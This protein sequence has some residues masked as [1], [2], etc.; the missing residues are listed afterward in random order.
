M[1]SLPDIKD[2]IQKECHRFLRR[3][4]GVWILMDESFDKR[5]S[6][7]LRKFENGRKHEKPDLL[8]PSDYLALPY[9]RHRTYKLEW[10][11]RQGSLEII[12]RLLVSRKKQLI[13]EVGSWNSWLTNRMTEEGHMVVAIDYFIDERDGLKAKKRY[14]ND[15][16]AIQ[17][18]ISNPLFFSVKFDSIIIN[19]CLQYFSN[20]IEYI[21]SLKALLK[22]DGKIIV[23]GL[24]LYRNPEKKKAQVKEYLQNSIIKSGIG[25]FNPTKGYL[26]FEDKE[27]MER[28]GFKF[29]PYYPKMYFRNIY[30][31]LNSSK[32]RYSYAIFSM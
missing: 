31:L 30:S 23:I 4:E 24:S 14:V 9:N 21:Q 18:D 20:P 19:H 5:L 3:D 27:K 12:N 10:V 1:P 11:F 25:F 6:G 16:I 26:D 2:I 28:Q 7:F 29:Y 17:A 13:L 8:K 15:W 22:E 32:P